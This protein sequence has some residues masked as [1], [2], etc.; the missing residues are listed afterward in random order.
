MFLPRRA[1]HSW[2]R[3]SGTRHAPSFE[4]GLWC[5]MGPRN[6][7]IIRHL[8]LFLSILAALAIPCMLLHPS[9]FQQSPSPAAAFTPAAPL[10]TGEAEQ[11]QGC[12][13]AEQPLIC[14]PSPKGE[15]GPYIALLRSCWQWGKE[16]EPSLPHSTGPHLRKGWPGSALGG[17]FSD[18]LWHIPAQSSITRDNTTTAG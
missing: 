5:W 1:G 11:E 14:A 18:R 2:I 10:P 3:L 15:L 6:P 17:F 12:A 4:T 13:K 7:S 16:R 9:S 8:T